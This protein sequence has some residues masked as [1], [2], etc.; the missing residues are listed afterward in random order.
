MKRRALLIFML[1]AL[2]SVGAYAGLRFDVGITIP[3]YVGIQF[4]TGE[5]GG[6]W[7][8]YTIVLPDLQLLYMVDLGLIRIGAGI[9][10]YTFIV[11]SLIMP[12]I[13]GEI[14][15]GSL[16]FHGSLFGGAFFFVGIINDSITGSVGGLDLN[17]SYKLTD[18][19][20]I[21]VGSLALVEF[22]PTYD[23]GATPFVAYGFCRF[24]FSF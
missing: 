2:L 6:V 17:V 15:L 16:L 14:Q 10:G 7:L 3:A 4:D 22:D 11:E 23:L 20:G 1:L 13:V 24:S 21:G 8:D 19:F 18:W 9:R 5:S 12:T